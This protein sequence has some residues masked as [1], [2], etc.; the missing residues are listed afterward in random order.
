MRIFDSTQTQS[1]STYLVFEH[2]NVNLLPRF[3]H[4][5]ILKDGN[6]WSPLAPLWVELDYTPTDFF[7]TEFTKKSINYIYN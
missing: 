1:E 5:N 6:L 3:E 7:Y 4:Y 2:Y